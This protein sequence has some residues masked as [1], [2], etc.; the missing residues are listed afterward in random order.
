MWEDTRVLGLIGS[1]SFF[2]CASSDMFN[3]GLMK[4]IC[5]IIEGRG[6]AGETVKQDQRDTSGHKG[7][8]NIVP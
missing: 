5:L 6:A 8:I 1:L 7:G 4:S 3:P 2:F